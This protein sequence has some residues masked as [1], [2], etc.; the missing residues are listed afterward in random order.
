MIKVTIIILHF[1]NQKITDGCLSSI[2]KLKVKD[3]ELETIAVNNNPE[4]KID[5]L[6]KKY[7]NVIFL[8]TKENLGFTGG[9]NLGIKKALK[10]GADFVFLLNN[11]TLLSENLLVELLKVAES[12]KQIGI[13]APKIYFAPGH[14]FHHDK[15]QEKEKGKVFWYAGGLFDWQNII[16]SHRGVDGVDH[17]QYDKIIT[18]DFAS[19]CGVLIKKEVFEKV[20]FFDQR[21][22]LYLEDVDLCQRAKIAGFKVLYVPQAVLWHLNA[23]SSAVGGFLHDYYLT[24]NRLLFGF[25]YA[26]FRTKVA[27]IK[28]SLRLLSSGRFWQKKGVLDFYFRKFGQG[29]FKP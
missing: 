12:D 6:K 2:E 8:E 3:F 1:N 19:G 13:L 27:L 25:K 4:Q 9:N 5:S 23:G 17:G 28:E 11:D 10:N 15:Y 29:S 16:A 14:E 7:Q 20:G 24:R 18:T 22:F 21:Y 26:S